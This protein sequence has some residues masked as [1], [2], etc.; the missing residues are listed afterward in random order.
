M[1][2]RLD[3]TP[4]TIAV[5]LPI[6][7][8]I[9]AGWPDVGD[10]GEPHVTVVY[11]GEG[12]EQDLERVVQIVREESAA[13]VGETALLDG[14]DY[15]ENDKRV[16]FVRVA[17]PASVVAARDRIKDA[18]DA[19]RID[20]AHVE[21]DQRRSDGT[22]P[23]DGSWV[24]HATL[25][26]LDL[27]TDYT[28]PVP[29]GEWTIDAVQVW[30]GD[31]RI[32]V[33]PEDVAETIVD[34][35]VA[36]IQDAAPRQGDLFAPAVH[37]ESRTQTI[38]V[39]R[40]DA[41][42][43]LPPE[44]LANGWRR[45]PV[46]FSKAGNV[47]EY[48]IGGKLTREWRDPR[49]VFDRASMD[50]GIGVPWELRHSTNLLTPDTVRGVARGCVLSVDPHEDGIHTAGHAMAWDRDLFEAIDGP[51]REVSVANRVKLDLRPGHTDDGQ[52]FDAR[53]VGFV[54]NSLASV[55]QGN[56]GTARVLSERLDGDTVT[57]ADALLDIVASRATPTATVYFDLTAWVRHD[58]AHQPTPQK[59]APTMK[60]EMIKILMAAAPGLA[61]RLGVEEADVEAILAGE[62]TPEQ[63]GMLSELLT[64][65]TDAEPPVTLEE[66][67]EIKPPGDAP[68]R[69][70][71]DGVPVMLGDVEYMLPEAVAGPIAELFLALQGQVAA[72]DART[73]TLTVR[74]D[75]ANKDIANRAALM[76][77]MVTRVDADAQAATAALVGG[78][79]IEMARR[80]H[81]FEFVPVARKDAKG[82]E[83][84]IKLID[85]QMAAL[86][87]AFGDKAPAMIDRLDAAPEAAR[88]WM[89]AERLIEARAILDA[90][91]HKGEEVRATIDQARKDGAER[92]TA[93]GEDRIAAGKKRQPQVAAAYLGQ[94]QPTGD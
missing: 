32:D 52:P 43:L 4:E 81:G 30:R 65:K 59:D 38:E 26:Y 92:K 37:T 84:P 71:M 11:V 73:D 39:L 51:A 48:M 45:Y 70:D 24:P 50:S 44:I 83:L 72:A 8:E 16:A 9:A 75:A 35:S 54:W 93:E 3:V 23:R 53:Q 1:A 15:F 10:N 74:Y 58:S 28:G 29:A 22:G 64:A 5:M 57:R 79:A 42:E 66:D 85:W 34:G 87:G 69:E 91:G 19:A 36:D 55:G 88:A 17:L 94:P 46:L 20:V 77:G 61:E 86:T 25:A 56:A 63:L 6:P 7:A 13:F 76:I 90:K 78:D 12:S 60:P 14:L 49:G 40:A 67:A 27:G 41:A 33:V 62:M 47:Q 89:I 82:V 2:D 31:T 80:S 18:L 21:I 68:E